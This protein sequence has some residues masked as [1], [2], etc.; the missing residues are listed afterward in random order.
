MKDLGYVFDWDMTLHKQEV[1]LH[2][3]RPERIESIH[4]FSILRGLL[5]KFR[6]VTPIKA[7]KEYLTTLHTSEYLEKLKSIQEKVIK[8]KETHKTCKKL[9]KEFDQKKA[10]R[11]KIKNKELP[12][13]EIEALQ[14]MFED[15]KIEQPKFVDIINK[16]FD[17]EERKL[18]KAYPHD[19]YRNIGA[20][21]F[22][23]EYTL[24]SAQLSAGAVK[25][26]VD[27]MFGAKDK[28]LNR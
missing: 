28:V 21:N 12:E 18:L 22:E 10:L 1:G 6:L 3:E 15:L 25:V 11:E 24:D 4:K 17:E 7:S 16:N 8:Y 9:K 13:D 23:N 5:S 26:A 19:I 2:V 14:V 27:K 20:D